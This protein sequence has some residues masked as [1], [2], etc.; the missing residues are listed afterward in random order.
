V[1]IFSGSYDPKL[2]VL[3]RRT[4]RRSLSSEQSPLRS[5]FQDRLHQSPSEPAFTQWCCYG[6]QWRSTRC[7][8]SVSRH[9][10]R[11]N[12][13][14]RD[15]TRRACR[16]DVGFLKKN[17]IK[18]RKRNSFLRNKKGE[19]TDLASVLHLHGE[20]MSVRE[21]R[22]GAYLASFTSAWWTR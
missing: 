12:A 6:T 15:A 19:R 7:H 11:R 16:T 4:K 22:S 3:S 20:N 1:F 17:K 10:T 2:Y 13:T 18:E 9:V 14:R 8:D 5:P 21:R